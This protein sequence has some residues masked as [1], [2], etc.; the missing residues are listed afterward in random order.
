MPPKGD[1]TQALLEAAEVALAWVDARERHANAAE[2]ARLYKCW[3][4]LMRAAVAR[5]TDARD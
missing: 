1:P 2:L 4:Q 3:V 5:G